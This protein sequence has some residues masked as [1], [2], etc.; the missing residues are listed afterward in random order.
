M[1]GIFPEDD[2]QVATAP[3]GGSIFHITKTESRLSL[4]RFLQAPELELFY[5]TA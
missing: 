4:N 1:S 2:V 5:L 3:E